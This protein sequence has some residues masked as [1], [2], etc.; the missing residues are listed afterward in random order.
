MDPDLISIFVKHPVSLNP[1]LKNFSP[2]HGRAEASRDMKKMTHE[3]KM[4]QTACI[5]DKDG[6]VEHSILL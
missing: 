6:L 5:M 1:W 4:H 3:Q 2:V